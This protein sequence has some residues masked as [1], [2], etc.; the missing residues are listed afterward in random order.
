[1][2]RLVKTD[3]GI[4]RRARPPLKLGTWL[5]GSLAYS[6]AATLATVVVFEAHWW[7]TRGS[8]DSDLGPW[9]PVLICAVAGFVTS[10]WGPAL[11]A[12]LVHPLGA[13]RWRFVG[14]SA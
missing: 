8:F 2:E 6:A 14:L 12:G 1:M 4:V 9:I 3:D 5:L 10:L 7:I 11:L 13:S